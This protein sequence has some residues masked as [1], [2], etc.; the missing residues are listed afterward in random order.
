MKSKPVHL[1]TTHPHDV[2]EGIEPEELIVE[3]EKEAIVRAIDRWIEFYNRM[4]YRGSIILE[5]TINRH[6]YF[7]ILFR[8]SIIVLSAS[9]TVI[10][11][12]PTVAKE[13]IT[14]TAGFLTILTGIET[15]FKFSERQAEILRQQ[16]EIQA[17]RDELGYE[18]TVKVE[19]EHNAEARLNAAKQLLLEGPIAY[20]DILNKY[21]FKSKE[22]ER[23]LKGWKSMNVQ[24]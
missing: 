7:S 2:H 23:D 10:S 17:K 11:S 16:R 22:E 20:N 21:A 19:L 12:F 5:R 24:K 15:Y 13:I 6:R 14:V 18:W 4:H 8:V 1:H 9:L 3:N